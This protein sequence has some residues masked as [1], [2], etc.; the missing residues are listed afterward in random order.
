MSLYQH[1]RNPRTKKVQKTQDLDEWVTE[2]TTLCIDLAQHE[3]RFYAR[4]S[5]FEKDS[6][7]WSVWGGSF[8]RLIEDRC[9]IDS[10]RYRAYVRAVE[11][12]GKKAAED[13][14]IDA[15]SALRVKR[16][17]EEQATPLYDAVATRVRGFKRSVGHSPG[18]SKVRTIV[19]EES[20][21][22]G[23]DEKRAAPVSAPL[24]IAIGALARIA[25]GTMSVA[26]MVRAAKKALTA[27]EQTNAARAA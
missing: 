20:L 14:G 5:D 19:R 12:V 6:E 22:L 2:L 11:L 15:A 18:L 10:A 17:P 27:I 13:M 8:D 1:E 3:A 26:E 7:A 21:R 25:D 16:L 23:I 24:Q 4:V 9:G